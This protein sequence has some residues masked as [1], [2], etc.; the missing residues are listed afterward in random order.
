MAL[1]FSLLEE[2]DMK[3]LLIANDGGG[4]CDSVEIPEGST[5]SELFKKHYPNRNASE[6][7]IRVNRQNVE[8]RQTL[9]PNDRVSFTPVKI[10]G[11]Q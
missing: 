10:E 11:A 8:S 6:F 3:V 4:F 2:V 1:L 9:A 7:L 5:V